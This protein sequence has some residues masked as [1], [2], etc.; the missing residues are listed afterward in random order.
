MQD[1]LFSFT[2]LTN[3]EVHLRTETKKKLRASNLGS[4]LDPLRL[5]PGPK[6]RQVFS[7]GAQRKQSPR[8]QIFFKGF[9]NNNNNNDNHFFLVPRSCSPGARSVRLTIW[10]SATGQNIGLRTGARAAPCFIGAVRSKCWIQLGYLWWTC[11][12]LEFINQHNLYIVI[13][14]M[15]GPQLEW[16]LLTPEK[17]L[18][19]TK[20]PSP[21]TV[22]YDM[23]RFRVLHGTI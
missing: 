12:L 21:K 3:W 16:W 9:C 11:V 4:F 10:S 13:W 7:F 23:D 17:W 18:E 6:L 1:I 15:T 14:T 20:G 22:T 2:P 8:S 5:F 19:T